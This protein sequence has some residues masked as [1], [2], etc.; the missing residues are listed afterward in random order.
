VKLQK[1]G[2][3]RAPAIGAR[4]IGLLA[5]LSEAVAVSGDEGAARDIVLHEIR[6]AVDS[7]EIDPMGN[8]LAIKRGKGARRPKVMLAAHMDEVGFMLVEKNGKGLFKFETVGGIDPRQLPG[9][10][11]WVGSAKT[12]GVI[13]PKTLH[14]TP[15]P[16]REKAVGVD[17]LQ[18][19]LGPG[20][21]NK[22]KPG[23][24]G[25]FATTFRRM[26]PSLAG[27][28][29]D[30]RIGVATLIQLIRHAPPNIDLLAAFTVQEEIGL[31]G[32]KTAAHALNPDLA[33]ALDCTPAKDQPIW[34]GT[35]NTEYNS[36]LGQGPAVYLADM[37]TFADRGLADLMRAAGE[38]YAIPYQIR[39]PGGGRTDA[40]AIHLQREGI[41]SISVSVPER[42]IHTAAAIVRLAD[43]RNT[44]ALVHAA[45]SHLNSDFLEG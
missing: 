33:I 2:K 28:A 23:D 21:E 9:K 13:G 6:Q 34:D 24:W 17:S 3:W 43:W 36:L 5:R 11:V 7:V 38:T 41:P 12:P 44:L 39:Q 15:I 42:Y 18:I 14:L 1:N 10:R 40:G 27:K 29:L 37:G 26:G 4:E 25:T 16:E 30:D 45:L 19:D 35:E 8:V 20:N 22:A 32:A 31:R